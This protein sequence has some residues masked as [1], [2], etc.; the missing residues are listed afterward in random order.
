[1]WQNVNTEVLLTWF[2]F[3]AKIRSS[4]GE[5]VHGEWQKYTPPSP[6]L[7][8]DEGLKNIGRSMSIRNLIF[9]FNSVTVSYLIRYDSLLQ[10]A[11]DVI[12]KCNSFITKCDSY[13]KMQRFYYKMRQLLQNATF[14]TN[15][16]ST[17]LYSGH[18]NVGD[19]FFKNGW[20]Y[21]QILLI[22]PVMADSL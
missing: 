5:C 11:T 22:K 15:C 6:P 21:G 13:Y 1:M 20:N 7:S 19:T 12:T 4:S 17:A 2:R 14:I 10:N 9:G 18:L 8:K 16:N 3:Q